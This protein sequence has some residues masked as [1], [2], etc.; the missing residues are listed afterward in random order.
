[1]R[2]KAVHHRVNTRAECSTRGIHSA[3]ADRRSRPPEARRSLWYIVFRSRAAGTH[4]TKSRREQISESK[5][6][7]R[8]LTNFMNAPAKMD[9]ADGV[10]V[11]I[12][13]EDTWHAFRAT[14]EDSD[15]VVIDCRDSLLLH[16]C[17]HFLAFPWARRPLVAVDLVLR[18]PERLKSRIGALGKRVMFS[19]IDHYIHYFRDLSAYAHHFGIPPDRSSYVPFKVNII[20]VNV[21]AA[22]YGEDYITAVGVSLRDYD[23]YIRAIAGLPYPAVIS[24]FCLA[25]FE[26]RDASFHWTS[27]NVPPNLTIVPDSGKREEFIRNLAKARIVV[28]PTLSS[29]ICASGLSSYLDAMSLG[30]CV[31]VSHG[32]GASDLLTE[33]QALLVPPQ[34]PG[35]L[36]EAIQIAWE[37]HE[38]RRRIADNGRRYALSLGGEQDLL[39]R[40]LRQS[41]EAVRGAMPSR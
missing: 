5:T 24:E 15:M 28:I 36:K 35:A 22:D 3:T 21:P 19:R 31:I 41:V 39:Q 32:P 16:T 8:I 37:D 26:G 10:G 20:D 33:N 12:A 40:V 13:R 7:M 17:A 25:N 27:Q 14:L 9:L 34:D 6:A 18:K 4:T 29:S 2:R 30:K 23:T 1:V 38:L 11:Q